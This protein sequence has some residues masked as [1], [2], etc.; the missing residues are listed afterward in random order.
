VEISTQGDQVTQDRDLR[1]LS[2]HATLC[3]QSWPLTI[4]HSCQEAVDQA[5]V[6][7]C[8]TGYSLDIMVRDERMVV[9]VD[10]PTHFCHGSRQPLGRTVLKHRHLRGMGYT[11][12]TVPFWDWKVKGDDEVSSGGAQGVVGDEAKRAYLEN[13]IR[14]ALECKEAVG[15][16][17][18]HQD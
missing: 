4:A 7:L 15:Q 6:N 13:Q 18:E 16:G 11:L 12:V 1:N 3:I 10:G 17:Y 2:K 8:S 14:V 9:E 5:N